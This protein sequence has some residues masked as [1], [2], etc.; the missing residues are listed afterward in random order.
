MNISKRTDYALRAMVQL[1]MVYSDRKYLSAKE[2]SKSEGIPRKFLEQILSTLKSVGYVESRIGPG[3]GYMLIKTPQEITFGDLIRLFEGDIAPIGCVK[4]DHPKFCS[5]KWHCR[6]H[7][8]MADLRDA[9]SGVVD[10]TTLADV[11]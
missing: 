5:E 4:I 7:K 1:A 8:V 3:G 6:F 9:I 11:C 2:I 10:N